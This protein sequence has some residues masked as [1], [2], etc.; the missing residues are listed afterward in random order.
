VDQLGPYA[1]QYS[2]DSAA[3]FGPALQARLALTARRRGDLEAEQAALALA[4]EQL[5]ALRQA[6]PAWPA[7]AVVE[8]LLATVRGDEAAAAAA[9][10]GAE[11]CDRTAAAAQREIEQLVAG[12]GSG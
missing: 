10:A 7:A 12:E 9:F 11:Q 4:E 3:L 8:G 2:Y 6:V 5:A 1:A